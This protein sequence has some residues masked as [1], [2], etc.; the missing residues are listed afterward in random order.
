MTTFLAANYYDFCFNLCEKL[1]ICSPECEPFY[2]CY[3]YFMDSYNKS[4]FS[5]SIVV[6]SGFVRGIALFWNAKQKIRFRA[7]PSLLTPPPPIVQSLGTSI[8]PNPLSP[9]PSLSLPSP[10]YPVPLP[11]MNV[12][13][14]SV[15]PTSLRLIRGSQRN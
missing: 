13:H 7:L 12:L 11:T 5:H 14:Q 6:V 3:K 10:S 4:Q 8:S 9:P 2:K 15:T 1:V